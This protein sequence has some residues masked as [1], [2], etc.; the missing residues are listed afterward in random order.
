MAFQAS[1]CSVYHTKSF[2]VTMGLSTLIGFVCA[3]APMDSA[4]THTLSNVLIF[5][6][7]SLVMVKRC[8]ELH[9]CIHRKNRIVHGNEEKIYISLSNFV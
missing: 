6:I 1:F 7:L 2:S 9:H 4:R 5:L 8:A 3:C